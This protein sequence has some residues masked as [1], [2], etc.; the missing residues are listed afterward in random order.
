M[1]TTTLNDPASWSKPDPMSDPKSLE[2]GFR[3]KRFAHVR[4]LIEASVARTGRADILDLGGTESYWVIGA[5]YL[6]SLG[7]R[8]SI[9]MVNNEEAPDA[10]GAQFTNIL[11]DGCAPDLFAGRQFDIVHSNS[12]IEH[13]GERDKMKAFADN[14]RR[15]GRNYYVQTPNYWFPLEPHFRV[16]GFQYLPLAVRAGLMRR[17]NIGFFPRAKTAE[18]AWDNVRE[19]RLLDR[20]MMREFFPDADIRMEKVA[21][22]NKSIMAVKRAD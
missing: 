4:E 22:L 12:V 10:V 5:D 20:R 14:V 13:V 8:V 6:K 19:V 17:F 15:L 7:D 18:E 11:G 9:T 1:S 16:V 2:R 21:G 3:S